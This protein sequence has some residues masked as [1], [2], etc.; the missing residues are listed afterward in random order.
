MEKNDFTK[1]HN[2][3]MFNTIVMDLA[4]DEERDAARIIIEFEWN[5][6]HLV[7]TDMQLT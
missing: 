7:V 6:K 4:R 1:Q 5:D 2:H 3:L